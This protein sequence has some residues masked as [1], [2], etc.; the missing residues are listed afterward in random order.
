MSK[1]LIYLIK[2]LTRTEKRYIHLN[3]KTFSFDEDKNVFLTDFNTVERYVKEGKEKGKLKI[4][5]NSTRLYHK[6]LDIL[7]LLYKEDLY[8]NE[9]DNRLIKHSQILFLK[10]FYEEGL[11]HLNKVIYAENSYSYLLRIEAIELKIKAAI[12]FS[13]VDYLRKQFESDKQLISKLSRLYFNLL[14]FEGIW[15]MTKVES[16]EASFYGNNKKFFKRHK[17]L[18]SDEK[19]AYSPNAKIFFYKINGFLAI[20]NGDPEKALECAQ[21][22]IALYNENQI[23]LNNEFGEYLRSIRNL[24]IALIYQ[25][26]FD[27]AESLLDKTGLIIMSNPKSKLPHLKHDIFTVNVLLRMDIWIA[28]ERIKENLHW[29]KPMETL[30]HENEEY[31]GSDEKITTYYHFIVFSLNKNSYKN[32]IQ[33]I[34]RAI[35]QTGNQRVD[36]KNLILLSEL[37]IHFNLG[38]IE[39][40]LSKLQSYRRYLEKGNHFFE[41]EKNICKELQKLADKP[42]DTKLHQSL[43]KFIKQ[44]LAKENKLRYAPFLPTN[45]LKTP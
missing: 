19:Y 31:L 2:S 36:I 29:I 10:G 43:Q 26:K 33:Y 27:E 13:D 15:A 32:A 7:F 24:C 17:K 28:S 6:I 8:E 44:S 11:K 1:N 41:F 30:F 23:I 14:Q 3:M 12:K 4:K 35:I 9:K 40:F 16:S 42:H 20:R 25:Q 38:N 22:T 5:G 45:Y 34:N 18:L 37:V 39:L 21:K